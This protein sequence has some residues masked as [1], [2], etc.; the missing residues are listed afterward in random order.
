M[1]TVRAGAPDLPVPIPVLPCTGASI[2]NDG[3][4]IGPYC[5]LYWSVFE[6]YLIVLGSYW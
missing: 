2:K 5:C 1:Q 4:C 3:V 6:L